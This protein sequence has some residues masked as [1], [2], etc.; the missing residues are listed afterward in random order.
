MLQGTLSRKGHNIKKM[1][2]FTNDLS[3]KKLIPTVYKEP[4]QQTRLGQNKQT[5]KPKGKVSEIKLKKHH[6]RRNSIKIQNGMSF[7]HACTHAKDL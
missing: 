4:V 7:I 3:D 2:I 5:S 1:E 6:T